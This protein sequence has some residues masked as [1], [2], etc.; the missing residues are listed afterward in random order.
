[1]F[2]KQIKQQ[3]LT[4]ESI[5]E[6]FRPISFFEKLLGEFPQRVQKLVPIVDIGTLPDEFELGIILIF[7]AS[8]FIGVRA[9]NELERKHIAYYLLS[10]RCRLL[11]FIVEFRYRFQ[12][13][14]IVRYF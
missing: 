13:V 14:Q 1:M 4:L 9:K 8:V 6:K 7:T 3:M 5:V 2:G 12:V 11:E 10:T